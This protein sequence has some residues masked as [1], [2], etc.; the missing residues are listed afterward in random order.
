MNI[1]G[2]NRMKMKQDN[3]R[4]NT[5]KL[6]VI[7][8]SCNWRSERELQYHLVKLHHSIDGEMKSVESLKDCLAQSRSESMVT[9]D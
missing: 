2:N 6:H 5:Q 4:L 1:S 3:L 7:V 8:R 9:G